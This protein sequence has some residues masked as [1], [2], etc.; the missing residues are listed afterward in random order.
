MSR[1]SGCP[2]GSRSSW[3]NFCQTKTSSDDPERWQMEKPRQKTNLRPVFVCE[4]LLDTFRVPAISDKLHFHYE[5]SW[6]RLFIYNFCSDGTGKWP[7]LVEGKR[8]GGK[9]ERG[10]RSFHD[11]STFYSSFKGLEITL[12]KFPDILRFKKNSNIPLVN[13]SR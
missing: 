3:I 12:L 11:L 10:K 2:E 5:L 4:V 13:F 7:F 1:I 9:E 8:R 6:I